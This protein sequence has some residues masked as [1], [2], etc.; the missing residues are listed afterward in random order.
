MEAMF[1]AIGV[2]VGRDKRIDAPPTLLRTS[3][4]WQCASLVPPYVCVCAGLFL[5]LLCMGCG[6]RGDN[7]ATIS[8]EVKLDGQPLEQGSIRFL[9]GEGVARSIAGGAIVKGR[10][11][12]SGVAGPAIGWNR[13]ELNGTRRTGRMIEKPFQQHGTVEET[14][15]AVGPQYN[16]AS[17]LKFEVKPGENTADFGIT[18][19]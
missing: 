8:G 1:R 4:R 10:Y 16:S 5:V 9:S 3:S 12:L 14:V 18:S 17:T 19:R 13:V 7:L 2:R 11:Q 15:E 6:H